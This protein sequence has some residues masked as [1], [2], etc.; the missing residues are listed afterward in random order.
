MSARKHDQGWTIGVEGRIGAFDL[1]ARFDT[2]PGVTALFGPSGAGKSLLLRAIAGLWKPATCCVAV[3]GH[4]LNDTQSGEAVPTPDRHLG[5]VFQDPLLFPH[6]SVADNL[7]FSPRALPLDGEEARAV[8]NL[9][10][11]NALLDRRP[12]HLSGGEGQRVALARALLSQP[13]ALLLDEPLSALDDER[14]EAVLPYLE[15][16]RDNVSLP[17]LYVSHRRDEILRLADHVVM[18]R[19]GVAEGAMTRDGFAQQGKV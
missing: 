11:L 14:R 17:M 6:M 12:R 16:L 4:V 1:I 9:L 13:R 3:A 7:T 15:R 18:V 5:A 8:L 2:G 10:D 19:G